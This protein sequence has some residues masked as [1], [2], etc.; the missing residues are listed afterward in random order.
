[1][2]KALEQLVLHEP[3]RRSDVTKWFADV[4]NFYLSCKPAD[5]VSDQ[6]V[7]SFMID[8]VGRFK[9]KELLP[10]IKKFFDQDLVDLKICGSYQ[11]FADNIEAP[12]QSDTKYSRLSIVEL[13]EEL[14][15]SSLRG[16]EDFA[17]ALND[18][19]FS[20]SQRLDDFEPHANL[21]GGF[22]DTA[23][24]TP[25]TPTNNTP[26]VKPAKTGRNEPCPCGSGK[27]HKKC[28]LN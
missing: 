25:G 8:S 26:L 20:D 22:L 10:T 11:G 5:N 3:E 24:S 9:G 23:A 15:E 19:L 21:M 28:C 12:L 1:V 6:H 17:S 13:Y 7:N 18:L 2:A 27:K 14:Y 16:S 4:F